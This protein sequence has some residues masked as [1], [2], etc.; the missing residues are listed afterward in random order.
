MPLS[1]PE[2]GDLRLHL[3]V[4]LHGGA[5]GSEAADVSLQFPRPA[6]HCVL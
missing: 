2:P 1:L 3:H 5:A 4:I 6:R